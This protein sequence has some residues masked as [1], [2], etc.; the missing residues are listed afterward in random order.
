[1]LVIHITYTED[2]ELD[3]AEHVRYGVRQG[4]GFTNVDW[5]ITV[6]QEQS[7]EQMRRLKPEDEIRKI[8]EQLYKIDE[9]Q[10]SEKSA[11]NRMV[12]D[13]YKDG[14]LKRYKEIMKEKEDQ[15]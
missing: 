13:M 11:V 14:L 5:K 1:M 10:R 12:L 6:S 8:R 15:K 2:T 3:L 9:D 4:L 7:F